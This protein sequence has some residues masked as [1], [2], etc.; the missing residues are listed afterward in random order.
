VVT[1]IL[2]LALFFFALDFCVPYTL[3]LYVGDFLG[4]GSHDIRDFRRLYGVLAWPR[5]A[6][7]LLAA[8]LG[9]LS[10]YNSGE[11]PSLLIAAL[12]GGAAWLFLLARDFVRAARRT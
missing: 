7:L 2:I 12:I 10:G 11:I 5:T 6:A 4:S 8:V 1:A 9:G 3:L